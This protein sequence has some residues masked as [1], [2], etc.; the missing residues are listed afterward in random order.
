MH[1]EWDVCKK[2]E[3][4]MKGSHSNEFY[5]C[6]EDSLW[7]DIVGKKDWE[8]MTVPRKCAYYAEYCLKE[9]NK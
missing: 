6:M 9:W 7:K 4:F 1:R 8:L 3:F 5:C 2:C